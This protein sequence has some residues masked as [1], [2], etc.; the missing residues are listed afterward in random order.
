[1]PL[2]QTLTSA[3]GVPGAR[4]SRRAKAGIPAWKRRNASVIQAW[5]V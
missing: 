3:S 1:M 2:E 5:C 4:P